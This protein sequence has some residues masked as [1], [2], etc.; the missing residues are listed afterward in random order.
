MM[1]NEIGILREKQ[2]LAKLQL[3]I[4]GIYSYNF[5]NILFKQQDI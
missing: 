3:M 5:L 2:S 4:K 1:N